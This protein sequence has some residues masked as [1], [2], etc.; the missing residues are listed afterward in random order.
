[1]NLLWNS[2]RQYSIQVVKVFKK[3]HYIIPLMSNLRVI[4]SQR[5]ILHLRIVEVYPLIVYSC[6][7]LKKQSQIVNL[8]GT[9]IEIMKKRR[10]LPI[11]FW[12]Y[13]LLHC[14]AKLFTCRPRKYLCFWE[15][16]IVCHTTI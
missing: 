9:L 10:V 13:E 14:V 16:N 2:Q 1:M 6:T 4:S 8:F 12:T 5:K 15:T 7:N 11:A 3:Y